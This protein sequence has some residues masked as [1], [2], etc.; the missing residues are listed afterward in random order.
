MGIDLS[1]IGKNTERHL[2]RDSGGSGKKQNPK[3]LGKEIKRGRP[4]IDEALLNQKV[5]VNLTENE[6]KQLEERANGIPLT[7][8]IRDFLK[9]G[10]II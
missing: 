10:K 3:K 6:K 5:T 7:K 9:K 8:Y 2:V 4:Q 1:Q